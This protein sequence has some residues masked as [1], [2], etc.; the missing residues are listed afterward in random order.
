MFSLHN[1][2]Q[3]RDGRLDDIS[4]MADIISNEELL[5]PGLAAVQEGNQG[6]GP[7]NVTPIAVREDLKNQAC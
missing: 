1:F 2:I 7:N 3:E 6:T 5:L 4:V